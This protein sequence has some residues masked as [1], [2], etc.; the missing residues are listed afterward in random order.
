MSTA[1]ASQV[2]TRPFLRLIRTV[3]RAAVLI[4]GCMLLAG[5]AIKP[6][7]IGATLNPPNCALVTTMMVP[8]DEAHPENVANSELVKDM[9]AAFR[10][11]GP[12]GAKMLILSGGSEHGAYGAGFLNGWA[13][14]RGGT[15][16]DFQV[17]TGVSTGALQSSAA[18]IGHP[19]TLL[20]GGYEIDGER[21]LLTPYS[22]VTGGADRS[23]LN[24]A[25]ALIG[26]G[27]LA[28]LAPARVR[29][30]AILH[31]AASSHGTETVLEAV[32][33]KAQ[34]GAK[35]YV[36]LVD[37][38]SGQAVAVDMSELA[39]R[40]LRA[41]GAKRDLLAGCYADAIIA[42]SSAP[43]AAPPVFIDGHMYVDGGLRF[44]LFADEAVEAVTPV[45]AVGPD[46]L[47]V[48]RPRAYAIVNAELASSPRCAGPSCFPGGRH[49]A[50]SFDEVALASEDILANQIYRLSKE[51][52][53]MRINAITTQIPSDAVMSARP[54]PTWNGETCQYWR[55]ADDR[56]YRPVQFHKRYMR[57]VI[58]VGRADYALHPAFH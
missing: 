6:P 46:Q 57:C 31:G 24:V 33:R 11:A 35:L 12:D 29:L 14:A 19:G 44:G 58:G 40:W 38:D 39:L 16:P 49:R 30:L 41:D 54:Y 13:E 10:T 52:L 23:K 4:G 18:F 26:H 15:L 28:N 8:R 50:W 17:V 34:T 22:G 20:K 45:I 55:D 51:R 32:A 53:E 43:M 48:A 1:L 37:L 27:A 36:G 56:D 21:D 5:C 42:S 25:R 7:V 9:K 2:D 3:R 47:P